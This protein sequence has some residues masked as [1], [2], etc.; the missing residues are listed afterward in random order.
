MPVSP[1]VRSAV[2]RA[3]SLRQILPLLLAFLLLTA[4]LPSTATL[5]QSPIAATAASAAT[6]ENGGGTEFVPGQVLVR[7]RSDAA[8]KSA[9]PAL[10]VLRAVDGD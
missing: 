7:F 4:S 8:A 9:E 1:F 5:A 10:G 3:L 6:K 2:V